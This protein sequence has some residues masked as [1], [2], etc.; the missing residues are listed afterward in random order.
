MGA[1][2]ILVRA[3]A[4]GDVLLLRRAVAALRRASDRVLLIAPASSGA[5][6]VGTGPTEVDEL[7]RW[8][9]S[10]VSALFAGEGP[11][12]PLRDRLRGLDLAVVYSRSAEL[13]R[14]FGHI[15]PR[16]IVHDPAPPGHIHASQWLA[17]PLAAMGL[18]APREMEPIRPAPAEAVKA[19]AIL[20]RLPERFLAIH[21]GSGSATKN[22]PPDR[23]AEL[24]E[25]VA[26]GRPWLLVEGPAD[27]EV[28]A[29][30]ARRP[31]PV[32]AH[33]LEP[34]TLGAVLASAGLFVGHD[35]GVSHLAAA[36][37]APTL[38]LFGPTDPDVWAPVGPRVRV[39]RAPEG[40]MDA[41]SVDAV[42][43]A[44]RQSVGC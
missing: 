40:R 33:G 9:R 35:S 10:E 15:V 43:A 5:V 25:A 23:F 16:V 27:A 7:L 4:L 22:W 3:G 12:E 26:P 20:A 39:V 29:R 41:L 42:L 36:W 28:V 30:L 31:G 38:A 34:R 37:G 11:S 1:R 21:P 17:Q 24:I 19:R 6:L 8:E 32:I 18:S 2:A 44:A 13:A 14:S